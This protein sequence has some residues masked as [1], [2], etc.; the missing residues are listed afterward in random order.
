MF[1]GVE[2]V[3][4]VVPAPFGAPVAVSERM[5]DASLAERTDSAQKVV[6]QYAAICADLDIKCS[7]V[8]V[9]GCPREDICIEAKRHKVD[10]VVMGSR[11]LGTLSR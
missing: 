6:D 3:A 7:K 5:I 2:R 10:F 1:S 8:V 11:G 9:A 4:D